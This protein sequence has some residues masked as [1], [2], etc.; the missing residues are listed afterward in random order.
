MTKILGDF[1]LD[2]FWDNSAYALKEYIGREVTDAD[3]A[4][5]ESELGYKL[6]RAYVELIKA[7]NGGIPTRANHRTSERTSWA[8]DH[9]AITGI[10]GIDRAKSSSLSGE[11][12]SQF[13]VDEWGYPPIG[14]YVCDC[15]SA[16]H[17]MICLDY[18]KCGPD[19]EPEV[20]HIDQ[21]SDYAITLVAN[22]FESFLRG[23][24]GDE[25]FL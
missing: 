17:D 9:V 19:G 3:V 8:A 1:E 24:D 21:E 13:W 11:C 6:P 10:F 18:S 4:S 12:G 14:I 5:I 22:N 20:V 7:Q 2:G 15:P 25:A 16:G 23:L